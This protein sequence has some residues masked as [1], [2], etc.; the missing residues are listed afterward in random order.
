MW[1]CCIFLG[2]KNR[3]LTGRFVVLLSNLLFETDASLTMS[4][5]SNSEDRSRKTR[6]LPKADYAVSSSTNIAHAHNDVTNK[7]S[8][9]GL[10]L[11]GERQHEVIYLQLYF[12]FT[13][14]RNKPVFFCC[15]LYFSAQLRCHRHTSLCTYTYVGLFGFLNYVRFVGIISSA[16]TLIV[17]Y[18][19]W[20]D[21]LLLANSRSISFTSC[22][23]SYINTWLQKVVA[24][25]FDGIHFMQQPQRRWVWIE[26][27]LNL[28]CS[29]YVCQQVKMLQPCQ[30]TTFST[31]N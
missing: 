2:N 20:E 4:V 6:R 3:T 26:Y 29:E 17:E 25:L 11:N 12:C 16:K 14:T 18:N 22:C 24:N 7:C 9:P 30:Q 31:Y 21:Q 8:L 5:T 15:P 1:L 27:E 13:F 23:H 19:L 10:L 28:Y